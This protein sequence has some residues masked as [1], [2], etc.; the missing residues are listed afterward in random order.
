MSSRLAIVRAAHLLDYLAVMREFGAPVDR[1]LAR[2]RLPLSIEDTPDLYVSVP[3]VIEWIAEWGRDVEPMELGF[4]AAQNASL[5]SLKPSHRAAIIGAQTGFRRLAALL[6]AA[7]REDSCLRTAIRV[8]ADDV[9]VVCDTTN[10]KDH[11]FICFAEWLNLQAVISVVRSVA[12]PRWC[13]SEM[14]F[15]S[16]FGMPEAV[17]R[18]FPDTRILVGQP[19]TA[20][21]IDR[22]LLARSTGEARPL[23]QS[24]SRLLSSVG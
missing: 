2:S 9:R 15:V 8:E 20:I 23:P 7:H 12:G 6:R 19:N 4:L 11:P 5:A 10:L 17:V 14:C 18:A 24:P 22:A 3:M 1:G 21:L 13:P 16:P